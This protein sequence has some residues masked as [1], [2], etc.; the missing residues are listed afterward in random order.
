MSAFAGSVSAATYG[1]PAT[2]TLIHVTGG[3]NLTATAIAVLWTAP[4]TAGT[5]VISKYS[6]VNNMPTLSSPTSGTL[7]GQITVTVVAASSGGAYSPVYSACYTK[8]AVANAVNTGALTSDSTDSSVV[9][10]AQWYIGIAL[11]DAYA[12]NLSAGNLVATAT[13]GGILNITSTGDG[14]ALS[15]GTG[16]T[17]VVSASGS[18]NNQTIGC[19][20]S[21]S[22]DCNASVIRSEI[23]GNNNN[24]VQTL[25]GGVVQSKIA[26]NGNYNN[27]THT[28]SGVGLH[29]GEI[30]VSGSGTSTLANAVTLTQSGAQTKNAVITSNGSNNNVIVIQ[31]D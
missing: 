4:T 3:A 29:S 31:S 26:V 1:D 30:T 19:G 25:S 20:T 24:T 17:V 27:V 22:S 5:Y 2:K 6:A 28:A 12:A 13:N 11:N 15:A 21:V 8:T 14:S 23:T 18:G 16:S 7:T 10:G 9:N